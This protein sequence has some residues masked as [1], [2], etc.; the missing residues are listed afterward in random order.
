MRLGGSRQ[1]EAEG[2]GTYGIAGFGTAAAL[3]EALGPPGAWHQ[4]AA[5]TAALD[6][7][8]SLHSVAVPARLQNDALAARFS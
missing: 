8:S 2:G 7:A 6:A 1:T 3:A 4:L 5:S